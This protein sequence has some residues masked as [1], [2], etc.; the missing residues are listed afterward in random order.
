RQRERRFHSTPGGHSL[1]SMN[2][3]LIAVLR[4]S[5]IEQAD[6]ARCGAACGR[7]NRSNH[8]PPSVPRPAQRRRDGFNSTDLMVTL[9]IM[10]VLGAILVTRVTAAKAKSRM[11]LCAANLGKVNR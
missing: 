3:R 6:P 2:T 8:V 11:A 5:P 7:G 10:S 1:K 4:E 9:A